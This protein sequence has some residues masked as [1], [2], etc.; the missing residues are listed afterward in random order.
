MEE[1]EFNRLQKYGDNAS[2]TRR[3]VSV[4]KDGALGELRCEMVRK[5]TVDDMSIFRFLRKAAII[6]SISK[7][8]YTQ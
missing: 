5:K 6:N 7:M 4:Y 3:M 2:Q 8:E 1:R